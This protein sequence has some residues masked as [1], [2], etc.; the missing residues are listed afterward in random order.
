MCTFSHVDSNILPGTHTTHTE[1]LQTG[2]PTD[3]ALDSPSHLD[4]DLR[5]AGSPFKND[6]SPLTAVSIVYQCK[7]R[8]LKTIKGTTSSLTIKSCGAKISH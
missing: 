7:Y 8:M 4:P 3:L 2:E 1:Q 6:Y 5:S